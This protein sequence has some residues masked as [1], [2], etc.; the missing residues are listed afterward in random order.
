MVECVKAHI[1]DVPYHADI[2][3]SYAIPSEMEGQITVGS[4]II[5]PFG[6]S[7]KQKVAIVTA[8]YS[9]QEQ[10][11]IKEI[12]SQ[13]SDYLSL[14]D[15]MM[16]LCRFMKSQTLCTIGDAVRCIVPAVM[17]TRTLPSERDRKMTILLTP[18]MSCTAK[19]PIYAFFANAFFEA[20]SDKVAFFFIFRLDRLPKRRYL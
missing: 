4:L 2:E 14:D 1:L 10:G 9:E 11:K 20:F 7:N 17:A 13:M 6:A 16:E 19:L 8:L 15:E 18:F 5:V 3:Y 12:K